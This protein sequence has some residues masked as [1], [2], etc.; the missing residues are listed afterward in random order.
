M[1]FKYRNIWTSNLLKQI[2][3]MYFCF[4]FD[5]ASV[6]LTLCIIY[7]VKYNFYAIFYI[8]FALF[9]FC[10]NSIKYFL[11]SNNILKFEL[12]QFFKFS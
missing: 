6:F 9:Y 1:F 12:V 7:V 10:S 11:H 8:N 5:T 3:K 4:I 2:F